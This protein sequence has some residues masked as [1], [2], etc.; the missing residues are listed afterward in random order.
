MRTGFHDPVPSRTWSSTRSSFDPWRA[1]GRCTCPCSSPRR[2]TRSCG[3]RTG[4]RTGRS[5]RTRSGLASY[6]PTS[7]RWRCPTWWE[8]SATSRSWTPPKLKHKCAPRLPSKWYLEFRTQHL[9]PSPSSRRKTDHETANQERKLTP[10]QKKEKS[11]R[12]L[13][14]DVT[15]GINVAVYR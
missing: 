5:G 6:P 12:K 9:L 3:A 14:E 8:S 15:S 4:E 1:R 13:K 2:S 11:A 10:A 7:P